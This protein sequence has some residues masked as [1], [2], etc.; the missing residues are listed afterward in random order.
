MV[1]TG[2]A[3]CQ[4]STNPP[5]SSAAAH[6][7]KSGISSDQPGGSAGWRQ[8]SVPRTIATPV[9][10]WPARSRS[11]SRPALAH[12]A[13]R[14]PSSTRC[15]P[16]IAPATAEVVSSGSRAARIVTAKPASARQIAVVRPHTPAPITSTSGRPPLTGARYQAGQPCCLTHRQ[17]GWPAGS[18][19]TRQRSPPG[20]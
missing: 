20:W 2:A 16:Q 18:V 19:S 10:G 12:A 14:P 3:Y 5:G 9:P 15:G 17:N 4:P 8:A 6:R 11:V 7:R 13:T 1:S